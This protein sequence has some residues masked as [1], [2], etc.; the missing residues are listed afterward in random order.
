MKDREGLMFFVRLRY[1]SDVI[2]FLKKENLLMLQSSNAVVLN[3]SM[4]LASRH[5]SCPAA[6]AERPS[7]LL[8][9]RRRPALAGLAGRPLARRASL[10]RPLPGLGGRLDAPLRTCRGSA[11]RWG[12][13]WRGSRRSWIGRRPWWRLRR[14]RRASPGKRVSIG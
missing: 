10:R 7:L 9:R 11:G 14:L 5:P 13:R 4:R 1:K 2:S 12:R 8:Q 6:H 3:K